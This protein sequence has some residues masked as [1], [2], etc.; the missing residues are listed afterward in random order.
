MRGVQQRIEVE[1]WNTV[2]VSGVTL[3]GSGWYQL[4]VDSRV[5][6]P[7][8]YWTLGRSGDGLHS[9]DGTTSTYTY[10]LDRPGFTDKTLE[11]DG[12]VAT[13]DG[14]VAFNGGAGE[15]LY[16][17]HATTFARAS[18]SRGL[19]DPALNVPLA[20]SYWNGTAWASLATT[21]NEFGANPGTG[22]TTWTPPADWVQTEVNEIRGYWVKATSTSPQATPLVLDRADMMADYSAPSAPPSS[23]GGLPLAYKD[24]EGNEIDLDFLP[25]SREQ[26]APLP[27]EV[28]LGNTLEENEENQAEMNQANVSLDV[29][30]LPAEV[31]KPNEF[32]VGEAI[33]LWGELQ[34]SRKNV[35]STGTFRNLQV[36]SA[37]CDP[38]NAST[39]Y[40]TVTSENSVQAGRDGENLYPTTITQFIFVPQQVGTY[41]CKLRGY[42]QTVT[43]GSGTNEKP[44]GED[45]FLTALTGLDKSYIRASVVST[46]SA[47]SE[48][49]DVVV[50]RDSGWQLVGT[51][52][53]DSPIGA[54]VTIV[55]DVELTTCTNS[56]DDN[57]DCPAHTTNETTVTA[58]SKLVVTFAKQQQCPQISQEET[59]TIHTNIHHR[60]ISNMIERTVTQMATCQ[61]V[62][63]IQLWVQVTAGDEDGVQVHGLE[64][65]AD[66]FKPPHYSVLLRAIG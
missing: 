17:G 49:T 42:S 40:G 57:T 23:T 14:F 50:A 47:Q 20:W 29:V 11:A 6:D 15:S 22:D 28:I 16:F 39:K 62:V 66:P 46:G 13:P 34:T 19:T 53:G 51:L 45:G 10:G 5:D 48:V 9:W 55:G 25:I 21:H 38:S 32:I 33:L 56:R 43:Q 3:T 31:N 30:G 59:T 61:K 52:A 26:I 44:G 8:N 60:K 36:V 12:D 18:A 2:A 58:R 63:S 7:S 1:G 24:G 27:V 35:P 65:D 4:M 54:E 41:T 64:A 37:R